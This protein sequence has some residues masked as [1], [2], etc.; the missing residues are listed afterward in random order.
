MKKIKGNPAL[1]FNVGLVAV[2]AAVSFM[3]GS[4][5]FAISIQ[6]PTSA[7]PTQTQTTCTGIC[8]PLTTSS[9]TD[10]LGNLVTDAI[11]VAALIA[12]I[13]FIITG[14]QFIAARGNSDK[15]KEA[16]KHF[17]LVAIGTAILLSAWTAV[18][19]IKNTLVSSGLVNQNV[20]NQ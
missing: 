5:A 12:V 2:I 19:L 16:K 13:A 7:A 4:A 3:P 8:N 9:I 11:P 10:F 14:F 15:L 6:Q 20:F 17:L 1:L 18:Y